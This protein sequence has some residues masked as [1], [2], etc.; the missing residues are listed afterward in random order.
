MQSKVKK[1]ISKNNKG[2]KDAEA[3]ETTSGNESI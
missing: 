2:N 3:D 1:Q